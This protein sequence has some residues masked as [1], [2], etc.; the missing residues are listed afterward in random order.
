[1]AF[2]RSLDTKAMTEY[3]LCLSFELVVHREAAEYY[4]L[5]ELPQVI[6]NAMLLNES[7]KL[8]VLQGRVIRQPSLSSI[9]ALSNLSEFSKLNFAHRPDRGR[10]RELAHGEFPISGFPYPSSINTTSFSYIGYSSIHLYKGSGI[11]GRAISIPV[12]LVSMA[13]P[14]IYNTREMANYMRESASHLPCPLPEDFHALYPCFSLSEAEGAAAN[15]ELPKIVQAT[16][17]AMLLNEAGELGMA[18]DFTTEGL[19]S[20]LAGRRW[21]TFE[22]WM[23]CVNHVLRAVKL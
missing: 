5:P 6:F 16:I 23:G 1:M 13:F 2:P 3:A 17:Y 18:Y 14:S 11:K 22:V 21:S 7:E 9:G 12:S 10:V 19:K 4:E 20:A 15:F 8:G